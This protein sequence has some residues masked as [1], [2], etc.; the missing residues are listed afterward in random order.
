MGKRKFVP[1]SSQEQRDKEAAAF[2]LNAVQFSRA[3]RNGRVARVRLVYDQSLRNTKA[4]NVV[5]DTTTMEVWQAQPQN[6]LEGLTVEE[7]QEIVEAA[8]K[9][10]Q[11]T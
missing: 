1:A 6:D 10:L 5:Q 3:I 7:A 2:L 8:V 11:K 4:P 9:D